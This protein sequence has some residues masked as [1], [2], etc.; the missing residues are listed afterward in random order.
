MPKIHEKKEFSFFPLS[1]LP[2]FLPPFLPSFLLLGP[3]S[4]AILKLSLVATHGI[5]LQRSR[6]A[7]RSFL[8][9]S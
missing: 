3:C 1:L 5:L 2:F 4:L 9:S 7:G 6:E 8:G